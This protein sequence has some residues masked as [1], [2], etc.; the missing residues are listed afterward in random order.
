MAASF[1]SSANN[2]SAYGRPAPLHDPIL[3]SVSA[4]T[5]GGE[6]LRRYWHPVGV[7]ANVTTR[8]QM[9]R[10]LGEDLVLFRD[11]NGRP[12][13]LYPHCMHRGASLYYGKVDDRG[14][15]C[16]YHGWL[17]DVEGNCLEQPCEPN[18]GANLARARQPWYPVQERYGLVFAYMGPPERI[19]VLPRYDV[20]EDLQSD[21][22]L[23]V[24]G[25]GYG[26]YVDRVAD[27]VLPY[28]WL[29]HWENVI[30]PFHVY[31]LHSTFSG[32][33]F[34][35][36][37]SVMPQV[38]FKY[39]DG[40]VIYNAQRSLPDGRKMNRINAVLLP[41]IAC[42]SDLD[43]AAGR[44][45]V[46]SWDVPID[47]THFRVFFVAKRKEPGRFEGIPIQNGKTW[48]Q[49]TPEEHQD[50]PSDFEAQSSQG[51]ITKHSQ[52]HLVTSDRGIAMLRRLMKE[53]ISRVAK[54]EDPIGVVYGSTEH[55]VKV[56]AGNF[57]E[58]N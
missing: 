58:S 36:G 19:P 39:V 29:Q 54:G 7:S 5:P 23:E 4:G 37:F 13:L 45:S 25:T 17:F 51:A 52:E 47:E 11:K 35:D 31:V 26:G 22:F 38:D 30:D 55:L 12:G 8:P 40:G 46:L 48:T 16:C 32:V 6:Y 1:K 14:I 28:N 49:L 18:K 10:V 33:Q 15:R 53:Q 20:L 21:E 42:I 57:Y 56:P 24:D 34:V 9:V 41:T 3:T 2:G 43:L 50:F 44:C 27:P